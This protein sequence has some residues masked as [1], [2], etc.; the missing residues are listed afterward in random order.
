ME[1]PGVSYIS[2]SFCLAIEPQ[3]FHI[4]IYICGYIN[5]SILI[6]LSQSD[7]WYILILDDLN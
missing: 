5:L 2:Q 3:F 4:Y 6:S 7:G 1:V